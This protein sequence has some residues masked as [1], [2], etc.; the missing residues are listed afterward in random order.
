MAGAMEGRPDVG[1]GLVPGLPVTWRPRKGR[2]VPY[3]VAAVTL[4]VMAGIAVALPSHGLTAWHLVDRLEFF[5]FGLVVAAFLLWLARPRVSADDR[6]V[7]VVNLTRAR[8]LDYAEIVKV[9]LRRGDSWVML[10]LADGAS[11]A[12]M[13]IQAN[14]GERARRAARE[15]AA[16]V[17]AR[18]QPTRPPRPNA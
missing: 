17:A 5:S 4:A 13:G 16:L 12:A 11:L 2:V 1:P 14:D 7:T 15:L 6:G 8:R 18:S 3:A 10:D 9:N